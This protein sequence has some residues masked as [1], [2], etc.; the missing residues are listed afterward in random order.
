MLAYKAWRE[1]RARFLISASTLGCFSAAFVVLRPWIQYAARRPFAD[2]IVDSIY[3]GAVRNIFVILVVAFGIGGLALERAR[4]S[5][6]FTLALPLSRV[7]LVVSRAGVG[8]LEVAALAL[9]PTAVILGLAPLAGESFG[10]GEAIRYSMQWAATG[11]VLF[12]VSFLMS[13]WLTGGSAALTV[14]ILVIA[15]YASVLNVAALRTVPALNVFAL[16]DRPH[17]SAGRLG[18]A[19]FVALVLIAAAAWATERQDF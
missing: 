16:M 8:L 3:T 2:A 12:A 11:V 10:I 1:T 9:V 15:T 7:R 5:A 18:G 6:A 17:P 14:T 4:G 19:F 13:V